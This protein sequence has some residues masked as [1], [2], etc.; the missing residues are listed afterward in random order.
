MVNLIDI[1]LLGLGLGAV[2]Q[3]LFTRKVANK[4]LLLGF[5]VIVS[6]V[7]Y[8]GGI[9]ALGSGLISA[10]LM[11]GIGYLLWLFRVLGAGDVKLLMVL[12]LAFSWRVSLELLF[13]AFAWGTLFGVLG[14]LLN[15]NLWKEAKT[16]NFHPIL[17]I[18]S[19]S[20]KGHKI[21]FTVGIFLGLLSTW[22]MEAKGVHFL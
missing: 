12:S 6:L 22:L 20:V 18:R 4:S 14:I 13:Y 2:L 10:A 3:D 5:L 16:L 21:P 11:F 9:H 8:D 7:A 19:N 1:T 15:K 17:T